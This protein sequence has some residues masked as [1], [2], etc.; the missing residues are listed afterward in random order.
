VSISGQPPPILINGPTASGKTALAIA[1]AERLGGVIIN[2][3]SMQ[4]YQDLRVLTARPS[5]EEE[6]R[7]P[8][9]LFGD[10]DAAVRFSTGQWLAAAQAAIVEAQSQG[11]RPIVVGGTGLYFRALTE[12]LA[13]APPLTT[14]IE[15]LV[16]AEVAADP[17][18]AHRRLA[19]IDPAAATRISPNDHVRLIRALGIFEMTGET[20]T[21]LQAQS[22]TDEVSKGDWVRI[23]L[24]PDRTTLYRAI[25]DRFDVMLEMGAPE[26]ARA[27]AE[28][29]LD[30]VLPA[31]KAHGMPAFAAY[32][33]GEMSLDE[34]R[35]KAVLD[36][37]HYAKRQF[38]WIR[39]QMRDWTV[40]EDG[41]LE[42]RLSI[43]LS[44]AEQI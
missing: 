22:R 13:D 7:A 38:T 21:S 37:R 39:N 35:A 4:V 10:V 36:T 34:V 19:S 32:F 23:V 26:E 5:I 12:G 20:I 41:T 3:D 43:A 29:C 1:L 14:R 6:A 40:I 44:T 42:G 18:G 28:R 30:P 24:H 17:E 27:L 15:A 25:E 16:Q 9:L 2:A 31:M 33:R 11:W 8:H